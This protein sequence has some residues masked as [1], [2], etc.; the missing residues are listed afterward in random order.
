LS[1]V[2]PKPKKS[3]EPIRK[4]TDNPMNQSK[5]EVNT[6]VADAKRGKRCAS[7]SR[8]VFLTSDWMKI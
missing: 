5:L 6:I 4:N 2:K 3:L 8:L 1:V 7:E